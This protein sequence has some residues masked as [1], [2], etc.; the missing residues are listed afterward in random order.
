VNESD[1]RGVY[2]ETAASRGWTNT[3]LPPGTIARRAPRARRLEDARQEIRRKL[4]EMERHGT[5]PDGTIQ[6]SLNHLPLVLTMLMLANVAAAAALGRG[7]YRL[8]R[9][10]RSFEGPARHEGAQDF[11]SNKP[12][13]GTKFISKR[14]PSG[15]SNSTE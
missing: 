9:R 6:D 10:V 1:T 4:I 2:T 3:Q 5:F 11:P 7:T 12:F 15:S 13:P 8:V 14:M